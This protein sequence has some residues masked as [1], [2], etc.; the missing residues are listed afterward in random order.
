MGRRSTKFGI[1]SSISVLLLIGVLVIVNYL[2]DKHQKRWD[3]TAEHLH[4]L[5]DESIKVAGEVKT[6]IKVKA[7][8]PGAEEPQVRELLK[9]YTNQNAKIAVEFIDPDKQNQLAQQYQVTQYGTLRNP[10][11][12]EQ[13]VVGT[14]ILDAGDS[15]VE[16]IE[17]Q[18]D[19]TEEDVT[20]AL[21]KLVK[22]EK[23]NVYFISGHGEKVLN[24]TDREGYEVANGELAKAGY[25]VKAI[26]LASDLKI[27]ADAS[28]I[29]LAGP[30]TEPFAQENEALDAYLNGGGSLLLMLDPPPAATMKDFAEKWAVTLGNNRIIDPS[31]MGQL[32]GKGPDSPLVTSYGGHK[33]V[34]KF[35]LMTFFPQARS[36]QVSKTPPNGLSAETLIQ[37]SPQSWGE[38]DLTSNKVARD[39]KDLQGPVPIAGVITKD[40]AGGKK[41]RLVVFG[42]SDFA[43]NANYGNQG[44]GNLFLN[45]VKWLAHDEN[46][47]SIKAKSPSDRSLTMTETSGRT[48][49]ILVVALFPGAVLF[50]GIVVWVR[51]RR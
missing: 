33:I 11:T 24:G 31:G 1:N 21:T 49:M 14:I 20:N 5:S 2:G 46:F 19:V 39:D 45:T 17:K 27:P 42:D 23:K 10:M 3:M 47:V 35:N 18:D 38:S 25:V 40:A 8:Y 44:N 37:S 26:N 29:V 51:R 28:A 6:D 12:R 32:L 43:M 15:K 30:K 9:L 13:K 22:G 48:V 34:D 41:T 4:S 7:F 36:V 16:R 50:T